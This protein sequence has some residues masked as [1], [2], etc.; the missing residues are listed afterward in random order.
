MNLFCM[1]SEVTLLKAEE[2]ASSQCRSWIKRNL[3]MSALRTFLL[4][5]EANDWRE[6]VFN[7]TIEFKFVYFL[8]NTI[9]WKKFHQIE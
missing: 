1:F 6:G 7:K 2:E 9:L 8:E 4:T 5:E 3:F